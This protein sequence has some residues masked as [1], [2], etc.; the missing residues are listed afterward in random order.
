VLADW[1]DEQD[2]RFD[3]ERAKFI[4]RDIAASR[5]RHPPP[6]QVRR[7]E[8]E[9]VRRWLEPLREFISG[10]SFVRGL[11]QVT[12]SGPNFLKPDFLPVLG[13]EAF[14]FVQLVRLVED[15]F[16][17]PRMEAVVALPEFHHVCG[18]SASPFDPLGTHSA[19]RVFGSPNLT[20]LRHIEFRSA[21]P[22]AVGIQALAA[23][24]ALARL[25]KL[26]LAHNKLVDKAVMALTAGVHLLRLDVL[27]LSDNLIGDAGAEALAAAPTLSA[28]RE[29]DVRANPRLTER[30]RKRLR[31]KFADRA[32]L[33]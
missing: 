10:W 16:G 8:A 18:L 9:L 32:K 17:G 15:V 22:G 6:D 12:I 4:R 7:D 24:R 25:R 11:P 20:G 26:S 29:L 30:G 14:A 33:S 31:D 13:S 28:L 21:N 3:A 19:A 27:D 23:N 2:N 5:E 1:L